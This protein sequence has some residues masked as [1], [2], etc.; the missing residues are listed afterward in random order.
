MEFKFLIKSKRVIELELENTYIFD[1]SGNGIMLEEILKLTPKIKRFRIDIVQCNPHT[2]KII[3]EL[4]FENKIEF[5]QLNNI[6]DA[7][8]IAIDFAKFVAKNSA[9]NSKII[10]HFQPNVDQIY[11]LIFAKTVKAHVNEIWLEG[12]QPNVTIS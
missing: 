6:P 8:L 2:S 4:P 12:L 3:S 10:I 7:N 9:P 11:K 5:F 1:E